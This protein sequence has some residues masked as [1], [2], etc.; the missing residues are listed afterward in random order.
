MSFDKSRYVPGPQFS[1]LLKKNSV[2]SL[3]SFTSKAFC[4][5]KLSS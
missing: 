5:A 1:N 3:K 4:H 2:F